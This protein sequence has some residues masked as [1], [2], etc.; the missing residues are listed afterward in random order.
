MSTSTGHRR[1]TSERRPGR[2]TGA[3]DR[4]I[5]ERFPIG[6]AILVT[7]ADDEAWGTTSD[8]S[9][10][11]AFVETDTLL[12]VGTDVRIEFTA[13]GST[14]RRKV[15][16][17]GRVTRFVSVATAR[18]TNLVA[19]VGIQV[20][21]VILGEAA[22]SLALAARKIVI[23]RNPERPV[24]TTERSRAAAGIA[25]P[26][27]WGHD[28]PPAT[29]GFLSSITPSGLATIETAHPAPCDSRVYLHLEVPTND[30]PEVFKAIATVGRVQSSGVGDEWG[31]IVQLA[32]HTLD[33]E[34]VVQFLFDP[35]RSAGPG[36]VA[37]LETLHPGGSP[38][39]RRLGTTDA[40]SAPR[41][42]FPRPDEAPA[43]RSRGAARLEQ[44]LRA[45]ER[46]DWPRWGRILL[47]SM[48]AILGLSLFLTVLGWFQ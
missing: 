29:A 20:S 40:R 26:V 32:T 31:M 41:D 46:L 48:L 22:L 33:I 9:L 13:P 11:G 30:R 42:D 6:V 23:D 27:C 17:L 15:V 35:D 1:Q 16:A 10:G 21:S 38:V 14:D 47:F 8:L 37:G 12:P 24:G 36:E 7:G 5:H 43:A 18:H 4:R 34:R 28:L 3:D 45:T 44:I 2:Q 19:G 25:L 39:P